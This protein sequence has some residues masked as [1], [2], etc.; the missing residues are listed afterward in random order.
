M[1]YLELAEFP[2]ITS[3]WTTKKAVFKLLALSEGVAKRFQ[4]SSNGKAMIG[5]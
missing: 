5:D 1:R 3:R 2:L 4:T